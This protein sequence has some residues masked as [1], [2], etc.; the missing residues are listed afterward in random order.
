MTQIPTKERLALALDDLMVTTKDERVA[1]LILKARH[2]DYDDYESH[3]ATPQS[4]LVRDLLALGHEQL[5]K[6]VIN[7]EF[8][9]TREEAQAWYER[10]GKNILL[11]DSAVNALLHQAAKH[12]RKGRRY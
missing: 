6:R 8:D 10:E 9:G 5:V 11:S 3:S 4:D 2:G 7:G 12:A 1:P